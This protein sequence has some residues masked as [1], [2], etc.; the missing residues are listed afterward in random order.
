MLS[1]TR[2]MRALW[3]LDPEVTFLNH[4]SFGACPRAVQVAQQ[5]VRDEL[6]RQ[7][8]RF[9]RELDARLDAVRSELAHVLGAAAPGLAFIPNATTGVN[10][11]LRSFGFREGDEL[12]TTNHAYN[13]CNNALDFVA[14]ASGARV[15]VA[16]V[17][18][19]IDDPQEVVD[20]VLA[21]VT[22]RTRFALIDHVTSPTGLIFPVPTIVAELERRGIA[23]LVD[24]AHAPGMIP[25]ELDALGASYYTGNLHKWMCAPKGAAFLHVREDRRH[26]VRPT[27]I[28]HGAN[29]PRT[30]RS[31]YA[32]EFDWTG[33]D[34]PSAILAVPDALR[35]M[36]NLDP[37]GFDAVMQSN[38]D[39]ALAARSVLCTALGFDAPAPSSMIGSLA[40]I[41]L[42]DR[43]REP[44]RPHDLDPL[45]V[46]LHDRFGIEV[47]IVPFPRSP[48]RLVRISA[49]AY[50]EARD[51]ERLASAL[52]VLLGEGY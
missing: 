5:R 42:P 36:A 17:P 8:V 40:A 32:L 1:D 34:D 3:T 19:P 29:A 52:A 4:G 7:P 46:A 14:S 31:R 38:R 25:L 49:Q 28:S 23:V 22:E 44:E 2:A 20:A 10:A 26:G 27:V 6:E 13:A 21:A 48:R 45:Q 30:D 41:I 9:F 11:V 24:G 43:R 50:L 35:F 18:F 15:V 16:K 33:T 39:K 37:G 47:P 51:Y 12:L